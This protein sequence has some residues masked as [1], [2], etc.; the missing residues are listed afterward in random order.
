MALKAWRVR[1]AGPAEVA[2][3]RVAVSGEGRGARREQARRSGGKLGFR[4]ASIALVA[5]IVAIGVD[6]SS[7][8]LTS[9]TPSPV[10][11]G[12]GMEQFGGVP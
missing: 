4:L 3:E 11:C 6:D 9:Q 1:V 5:A 2:G 7:A 12:C 10:G 8:A